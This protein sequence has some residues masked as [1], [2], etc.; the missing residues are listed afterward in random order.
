MLCLLNRAQRIERS[1]AAL[2]LERAKRFEPLRSS[3]ERSSAALNRSAALC[4]ATAPA[5]R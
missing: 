2:N 4:V 3:I 5:R 1:F